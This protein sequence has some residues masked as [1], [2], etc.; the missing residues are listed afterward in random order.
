MCLAVTSVRPHQKWNWSGDEIIH[1]PVIP[2]VR[3]IPGVRGKRYE[4]DV[5]EYLSIAGN[6]I[7]Q[8]HLQE[9]LASLSAAERARLS[10]D[11]PGSFDAR[12]RAVAR[13]VSTAIGHSGRRGVTRNWL[14]PVETLAAREGDCED[15]AFLLAALL[16]ASGISNY[17]VRVAFGS[18]HVYGKPAR[19][20]DHAW[21]VYLNERGAWEILEPAA[22]PRRSRAKKG[23]RRSAPVAPRLDVEYVPHFVF[24]QQHLWRVRSNERR[25]DRP[26]TDYMDD[27]RFWKGFD[28]SF[29]TDIHE[30]VFDA[31]LVGMSDAD[32][33]VVKHES[34]ALDIDVL[35]YDPRDHFDFAYV[36]EGWK[37][38]RDRVKSRS[39][40]EFARAVHSVGDF[41]AH[42]YYAHFVQPVGGRLPPYDVANPPA[43]ALL[44]YDFDNL[45]PLPGTNR[46]TQE[47]AALWQGKLVSGQWWRWFTTYPSDL[48]DPAELALHRCLP[49]HDL[50]AVD[51]AT[52]KPTHKLYDEMEYQWQFALRRQAAVDHIRQ[53]FLASP[54]TKA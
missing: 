42:S 34:L 35:D 41:Y 24:N 19:R 38:V 25:A 1:Q 15:Q 4:I 27:R 43:A 13:H 53:L 12:A 40:V 32:L 20:F 26:L 36:D 5:R 30:S 33:D 45:G 37:R 14:F 9:L 47:A 29:A 50:V 44:H 54:P 39:L 16:L 49:D 23:A 6:A 3:P 10:S 52:R 2:A 18:L 22:R 28:P 17:C 7:V 21:V 51:S 31:A 46:T 48:K 8:R 11:A